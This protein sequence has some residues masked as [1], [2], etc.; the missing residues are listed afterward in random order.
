MNIHIPSEN[1]CS[2]MVQDLMKMLAVPKN[3]NNDSFCHPYLQYQTEWKPKYDPKVN[4]ANMFIQMCAI[5]GFLNEQ[6]KD[7]VLVKSLL[8]DSLKIKHPVKEKVLETKILK[9]RRI[10]RKKNEIVCF[11]HVTY[12]LIFLKTISAKIQIVAR[13]MVL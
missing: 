13:N 6:L 4:Y 12:L 5:H 7:E 10:R 2:N 8:Q 11:Y 1:N 3:I 9:T